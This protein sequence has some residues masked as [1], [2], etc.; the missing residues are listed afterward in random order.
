MVAK[1][2]A[3]TVL[4]RGGGGGASPLP[5]GRPHTGGRGYAS[6]GP[7]PALLP[8]SSRRGVTRNTTGTGFTLT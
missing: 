4:K 7:P 2:I 8:T 1:G 5:L 6:P 3:A